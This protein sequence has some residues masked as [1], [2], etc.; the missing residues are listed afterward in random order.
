MRSAA[1]QLMSLARVLWPHMACMETPST[2]IHRYR[3]TKR[4]PLWRLHRRCGS[5]PQ[6]RLLFGQ[7]RAAIASRPAPSWGAQES[8][9]ST[10]DRRKRVRPVLRVGGCQITQ[11]HHARALPHREVPGGGHGRRRRRAAAAPGRRGPRLRIC[12]R[13]Y[14]TAGDRNGD[15]R[16]AAG[17]QD[18]GADGRHGLARVRGPWCGEGDRCFSEDQ[19][20]PAHRLTKGGRPRAARGL[21]AGEE[22]CTGS[23]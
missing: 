5:K 10:H 11:S 14:N 9:D 8:N 3:S 22:V 20:R 12:G 6:T 2:S 15:G 23:A 4:P 13:Y 21:S 19:R 17:Q 16:R 7:P 1:A 18:G